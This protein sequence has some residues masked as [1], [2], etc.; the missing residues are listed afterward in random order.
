[1]GTD[2]SGKIKLLFLIRY[3]FNKGQDIYL[4]LGSYE[5]FLG[6][7]EIVDLLGQFRQ[8]YIKFINLISF[9]A[10]FGGFCIS[11]DELDLRNS[12]STNG[13]H[14][15]S[16]EKLVIKTTVLYEGLLK[17]RSNNRRPPENIIPSIIKNFNHP[18]NQQ[19]ERRRRTEILI[20]ISDISYMKDFI[21]I[22]RCLPLDLLKNIIELEVYL[23]Y[24]LNGA[25]IGMGLTGLDVDLMVILLVENKRACFKR[26]M[27]SFN[28]LILFIM[29]EN[30]LLVFDESQRNYQNY[31]S[32]LWCNTQLEKISFTADVY[33]PKVDVVST[34]EVVDPN[35]DELLRIY[36][37]LA[38]IFLS[39]F[40]YPIF[41]LYP[42]SLILIT[43]LNSLKLISFSYLM[44]E[45]IA[46]Q[47]LSLKI[48]HYFIILLEMYARSRNKAKF[49]RWN[50]WHT[51]TFQ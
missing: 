24:L 48:M 8:E 38:Q 45:K 43:L 29:L 2:V 14:I 28:A 19:K 11:K 47:E 6:W 3:F 50:I 33:D 26:R 37:A 13:S 34:R 30:H 40:L 21:R 1:M 27:L 41:L 15:E 10:G 23:F 35:G 49:A 17:Y 22:H 51:N 4:F 32:V 44:Y 25:L 46:L 42:N 39:N 9:M 16:R 5:E 36:I 18:T 12:K 20:S 31:E 7:R